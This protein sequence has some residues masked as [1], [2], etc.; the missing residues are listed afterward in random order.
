[1]TEK[2]RIDHESEEYRAWKD[3]SVSPEQSQAEPLELEPIKEF[4]PIVIGP[5]I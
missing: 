2:K 4:F 3:R 5:K 1:M